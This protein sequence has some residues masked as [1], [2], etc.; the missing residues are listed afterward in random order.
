MRKI[1]YS[2][3]ASS[4]TNQIAAS[5][6][7]DRQILHQNLCTACGDTSR[8]DSHTLYV[9]NADPKTELLVLYVQSTSMPG[10]IPGFMRI[11]TKEITDLRDIHRIQISLAPAYSLKGRRYYHSDRSHRIDW[12]MKQAASHGFKVKKCIEGSKECVYFNHGKNKGGNGSISYYN[13]V[14]DITITDS[15]LFEQAV[16]NGIGGGKA[17]GLGLIRAGE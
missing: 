10:D 2:T 11:N 5:Q 1:Y 9:L 14:C 13:Y 6:Y 12:F 7:L 3:Y 8:A 15:K 17:Y 4:I 16:L